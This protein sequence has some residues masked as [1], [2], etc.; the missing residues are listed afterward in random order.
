M[1]YKKF[2]ILSLCILTVIAI[3]SFVLGFIKTD[4]KLNQTK[5][6][7]FY[8]YNHST[9]S[10]QVTSESNNKLYEKLCSELENITTMTI[11]NRLIQGGN[12][13]EEPTQ[14]ISQTYGEVTL[15]LIKFEHIVIE[16][17]F[18]EK[19]Q[20]I[21]NVGG[22]H[23]MLEY[24]SL[25]FAIDETAPRLNVMCLSLTPSA[26]QN[27]VYN[28]SPMLVRSTTSGLFNTIRE[29]EIV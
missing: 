12:L 6:L 1:T 8:I 19:Q 13:T 23:K 24:Y 26:N 10:T 9:T 2:G 29:A 28:G 3:T 21:V 5:P 14:D 11:A 4:T 20:Q 18:E 27:K 16:V 17:I 15:N 22:N 7:A 25:A